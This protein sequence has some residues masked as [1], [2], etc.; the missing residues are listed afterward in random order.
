M[1]LYV[2]AVELSGIRRSPFQRDFFYSSV[3]WVHFSHKTDQ[4]NRTS[5]NLSRQKINKDMLSYKIERCVTFY[6]LCYHRVCLMTMPIWEKAYED[7]QFIWYN[8]SQRR[9]AGDACF[10]RE[11]DQV[12]L[13]R[14]QANLLHEKKNIVRLEFTKCVQHMTSHE[15]VGFLNKQILLL[16]NMTDLICNLRILFNSWSM[17][18]HIFSEAR[19]RWRKAISINNLICLLSRTSVVVTIAFL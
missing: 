6:V 4:R 9:T 13:Q 17:N 15:E 3:S 10:H 7:P 12:Q 19:N 11:Y 16:T 2:K 5:D 1:H 14:H 8:V 18:V